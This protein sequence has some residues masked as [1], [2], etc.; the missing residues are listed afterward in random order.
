MSS[1]EKRYIVSG[2]KRIEGWF[3]RVDAEIFHLLTA[4]QRRHALG[5]SVAEI[6]LHHG[7]SF[8]ALC[9][10]LQPGEQAYGIDLFESQHLNLDDSGSGVRAQVERNL[11]R[12]GIARSSVVLDGRSSDQV[13]REDILS[14]VGPVRFFSV[15]GG[16]W[17]AIVKSDLKLA[18]S[19][20]AEHGIIAL[21]DFLRPEWPE[22]SAGYFEWARERSRPIVPLAIGFNKLYLCAQEF[23]ERYSSALRE[24]A[25]LRLYCS[26]RYALAG[27]EIDIYQ[28]FAQPEWDLRTRLREYAKL[29]HPQL[30]WQVKALRPRLA[31][32]VSR[33]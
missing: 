18:E 29:Y 23:R 32:L 3:G 20:L 4:Y 5:G 31:R 9:L 17:T 2:R 10:A 25:F 22:V 6:G 26:K 28:R 11:S 24:S 13:S 21:D 12:A 27:C 30:Y 15:D 33:R 1:R 7:K 14:R 16:H 8:I 19:A